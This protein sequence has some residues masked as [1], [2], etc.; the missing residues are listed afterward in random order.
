MAASCGAI[1][2]AR[3]RATGAKASGAGA[4]AAAAASEAS[5]QP[6]ASSRSCKKPSRQNLVAFSRQIKHFSWLF[7]GK[8]YGFGHKML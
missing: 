1:G 8:L 4:R 3:R 7:E 5:S 6:S 2:T